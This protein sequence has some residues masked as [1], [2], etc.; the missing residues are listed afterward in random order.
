MYELKN[1]EAGTFNILKLILKKNYDND[2]LN[3]LTQRIKTVQSV[4]NT[5]N[6]AKFNQI[7]EENDYLILIRRKFTNNLEL[8]RD[9][10][11]ISFLHDNNCYKMLLILCDVISEFHKNGFYH[12]GIKLSNIFI[13]EESSEYLIADHCYKT[14]NLKD[15]YINKRTIN[16]I[17]PEELEGKEISIEIDMWLIGILLYKLVN[18]KYP[19]ESVTL[20]ESELKII[21]IEYKRIINTKNEEY[22]NIIEK[23][24]IKDG[25]NRMKI[26]DLKDEILKISKLKEIKEEEKTV[27]SLPSSEECVFIE[28]HKHIDIIITSNDKTITKVMP[29]NNFAHCYL[30]IKMNEGIHH[31]LYQ[32]HG[33]C[34]GFFF[35]G[36]LNN[37]YDGDALP[38]E[39]TSCCIAIVDQAAKLFG[40]N[41]YAVKDGI[42]NDIKAEDGGKYEIIFNCNK[43]EVHIKQENEKEVL[44]W[45][46][47]KLPLFPFVSILYPDFA[48]DLLNYYKQ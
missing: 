11:L 17:S 16:F 21:K 48:V 26:N 23:L 8:M 30:N 41:G 1:K 44:L 13:N 19:F 9:S 28:N 7:I 27:P 12:G 14:L 38:E 18:G 3:I 6:V 45:S 32:I 20:L 37:E 25:N 43:K 47:V 4:F 39:E 34:G 42:F 24:L 33:Y 15:L 35:G 40:C 22:N 29:I 5:S 31:F 36:S 2:L 10:E 46:N